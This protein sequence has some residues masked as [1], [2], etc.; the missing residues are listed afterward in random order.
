MYD[1]E[2][3]LSPPPVVVAPLESPSI[4]MGSFNLDDLMA[5]SLKAQVEAEVVKTARKKLSTRGIIN[6]GEREILDGI[7]KAW[8]VKREWNALALVATFEVQSCEHCGSQHSAFTGLYQR[9]RHRVSPIDRWVPTTQI[10]SEA[11][12]REIKAEYD[13]VP[14]CGQCLPDFGWAPPQP[15]A[16]Q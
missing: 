2:S 12:P 4:A 3:L 8:E 6:S 1:L 5:D 14:M 13:S 15:K 9:Q 11:L 10:A 7:V 16:S